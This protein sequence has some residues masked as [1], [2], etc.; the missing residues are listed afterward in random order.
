MRMT[1][2]PE[3]GTSAIR[4]PAVAG[5]F[6]PGD[7]MELLALVRSDLADAGATVD[8]GPTVDRGPIATAVASLAGILVPHAGLVFS[9]GVAAAAWHLAAAAASGARATHT[10]AGTTIVLLG[11]NHRARWLDGVGVWEAG[12]WRTPLGDIEVDEALAGEI[13]ACGPMFRI[14]R[15]AHRS[16]HSIEVQLPFLAVAMPGAR[17]VPLAI[18]TG[19]SAGA[20]EAGH[21][22]GV[23]LADRRMRGG[24][25]I[26]AISTDMAHY[27][28]ASVAAR[29]TEI[30][31][32]FILR[33]DPTGLADREAEITRSGLAGVVC[34]MCGIEPTVVGLAAL[35]AMGVTRGVHVAAATSADAGGPTDR[36]VG[37]LSAAFSR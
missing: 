11:T 24:Q 12:A 7:P 8:G 25:D 10:A 15:D 35:C 32:P 21:R 2:A 22:L 4:P 31:E 30:L 20:E 18:G 33:L 16:E 13:L 26:L 27:P 14:D 29:V 1:H 3:A 9:G 6:Y 19:T 34:G 37:Y 23:L 17:M 36:T 28:S 5:A